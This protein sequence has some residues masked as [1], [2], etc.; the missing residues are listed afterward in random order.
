MIL[1]LFWNSRLISSN[2]FFVRASK[3]EP[4]VRSFSSYGFGRNGEGSLYQFLYVGL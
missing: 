4:S 3:D 2:C 1:S